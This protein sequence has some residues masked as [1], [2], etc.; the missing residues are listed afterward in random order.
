MPLTDAV[1]AASFVL[2]SKTDHTIRANV[3]KGQII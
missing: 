3:H 2:L 1:R